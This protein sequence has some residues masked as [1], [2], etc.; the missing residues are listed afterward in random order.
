MAWCPSEKAMWTV[1]R[2]KI[3][4]VIS[5]QTPKAV[6]KIS[7]PLHRNTKLKTMTVCRWRQ[8]A[9]KYENLQKYHF[10]FNLLFKDKVFCQDKF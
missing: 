8:K 5:A 2:A 3:S 10:Y 4:S 6:M 7:L 1:N 9:L